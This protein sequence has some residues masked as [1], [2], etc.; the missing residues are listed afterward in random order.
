[1][2]YWQA[3]LFSSL[4]CFSLFTSINY[5]LCVEYR[6]WVIP[7]TYK[8]YLIWQVLGLRTHT[9]KRLS[10]RSIANVKAIYSSY[11]FPSRSRTQNTHPND[12]SYATAS[13]FPNSSYTFN[14]NCC[15]WPSWCFSTFF[16][17][18]HSCS[19]NIA[20]G[21]GRKFENYF[22]FQNLSTKL[23]LPSRINWWKNK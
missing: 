15:S 3:P 20:L 2:Y 11:F 4:V 8:V 21:N 17:T 22:A 6:L 19:E 14:F 18:A 9:Q 12:F 13:C 5:T 10:A 23:D 7:R 16:S 1:M